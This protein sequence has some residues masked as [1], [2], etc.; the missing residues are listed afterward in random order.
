MFT[1]ET[2]NQRDI[3]SD[4]Q[5]KKF[6]AE[7]LVIME[8]SAGALVE[9]IVNQYPIIDLVFIH[10]F[11]SLLAARDINEPFEVK[12]QTETVFGEFA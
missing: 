1:P 5:F 11:R 4:F 6:F 9:E 10:I 8:Q 3:F 12:I 2:E 7:F